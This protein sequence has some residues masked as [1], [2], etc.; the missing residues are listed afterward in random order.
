MCHYF[1]HGNYGLPPGTDTEKTSEFLNH[2][3]KLEYLTPVQWEAIAPTVAQCKELQE[4]LS[5]ER[6][7]AAV[8]R[9]YN[10]RNSPQPVE[11]SLKKS[12]K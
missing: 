4:A 8:Q 10:R 9:L 11:R 7:E 12:K 6:L 1:I 5:K 3:S 2:W